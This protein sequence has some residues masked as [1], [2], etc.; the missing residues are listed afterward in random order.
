MIIDSA[1]TRASMH[2]KIR[3]CHCGSELNFFFKNLTFW[4]V[5]LWLATNYAILLIFHPY[6]VT[7]EGSPRWV[8]VTSM[9]SPYH[10]DT[11]PDPHTYPHSPP[12]SAGGRLSLTYAGNAHR[13]RRQPIA[14]E[15]PKPHQSGAIPAVS[16]APLRH[17]SAARILEIDGEK[18]VY[19]SMYVRM[20]LCT[21]VCLYVRVCVSAWIGCKGLENALMILTFFIFTWKS[22]D[23]KKTRMEIFQHCN[24]MP[25]SRFLLSWTDELW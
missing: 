15:S 19:V 13:R 6:K 8:R 12:Q 21:C 1:S 25:K 5:E 4:W 3:G 2:F 17:R 7:L 22:K 9:R 14:R 10:H 20:N 23:I 11:E 24:K 16:S 18:C